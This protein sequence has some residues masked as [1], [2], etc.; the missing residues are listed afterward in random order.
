[1]VIVVFCF[2]LASKI[3]PVTSISFRVLILFPDASKD[4]FKFFILVPASLVKTAS[5]SLFVM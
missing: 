5:L 3:D 1:M 2:V 4:G